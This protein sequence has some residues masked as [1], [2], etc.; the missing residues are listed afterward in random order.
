MKAPRGANPAGRHP[1][2]RPGHGKAS[3]KPP[4]GPKPKEGIPAKMST[5]NPMPM[6]GSPMAGGRFSK[7]AKRMGGDYS[8]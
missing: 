1:H 4:M 3:P 6:P 7:F 2:M 8:E 5:G